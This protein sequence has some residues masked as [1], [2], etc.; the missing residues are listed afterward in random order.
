VQ[1][2]RLA[3]GIIAP[4]GCLLV[5]GTTLPEARGRG[6]YRALVRARWDVAVRRRTPA[7]VVAAAPSSQ[8]ILRRLGFQCVCLL[9]LQDRA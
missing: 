3:I 7:L 4:L 9:R 8:A 2:L 5:G 6:A 1:R